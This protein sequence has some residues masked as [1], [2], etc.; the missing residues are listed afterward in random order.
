MRRMVFLSAECYRV[1]AIKLVNTAV[2]IGL[3]DRA[4]R[5]NKSSIADL[6]GDAPN[7]HFHHFL[8]LTLHQLPSVTLGDQ[9]FYHRFSRYFAEAS[10]SIAELDFIPRLAC[11]N[12]WRAEE[13]VKESLSGLGDHQPCL[14][15]TFYAFP[16]IF[17]R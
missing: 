11:C 16:L 3:A 5:Q 6:V 8:G 15:S 17:A 2:Q 4:I 14:S 7:A 9:D 1:P 10:L 13:P 12:F